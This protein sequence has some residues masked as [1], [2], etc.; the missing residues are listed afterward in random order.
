MQSGDGA[1]SNIL[2]SSCASENDSNLL[3][4]PPRIACLDGRVTGR[5]DKQIR[6]ITAHHI[7]AAGSKGMKFG[8]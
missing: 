3:S 6:S 1:D 7:K 4:A 5:N 8:E 2:L